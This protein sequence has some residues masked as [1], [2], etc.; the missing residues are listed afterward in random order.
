MGE[1]EKSLDILDLVNDPKLSQH[2]YGIYKKCM[3]QDKLVF[4]LEY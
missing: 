3:I 2:A 1:L 4:K